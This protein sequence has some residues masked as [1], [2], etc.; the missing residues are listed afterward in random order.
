M[1][2]KPG[3]NL[4]R[5]SKEYTL[6][7]E[8]FAMLRN[9]VNRMQPFGLIGRR[10]RISDDAKEFEVMMGENLDGVIGTKFILGDKVT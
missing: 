3:I 7:S 6:D 4:L 10:D 2:G 1:Q 8:T 9:A 5:I